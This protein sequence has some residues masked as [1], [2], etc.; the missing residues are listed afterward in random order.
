MPRKTVNLKAEPGAR[1][2]RRVTQIES[3]ER[4]KR[5]LRERYEAKIRSLDDNLEDQ[6]REIAVELRSKGATLTKEDVLRGLN[7]KT[8][9]IEIEVK[10]E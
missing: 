2:T 5:E 7:R 10:N 8:G 1:I 4:K 9:E 3:I 6:A